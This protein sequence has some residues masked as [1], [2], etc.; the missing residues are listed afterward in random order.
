[1]TGEHVQCAHW[2]RDRRRISERWQMVV[3]EIR[4]WDDSAV[5]P[6][7]SLPGQH[8]HNTTATG[9]QRV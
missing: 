1:M 3:H 2:E 9:I 6:T 7:V 8:M 5:G 4:G